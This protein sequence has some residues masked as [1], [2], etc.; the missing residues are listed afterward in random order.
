MN[1]RRLV[2]IASALALNAGAFLQLKWLCPQIMWCHAC[3][4]SVVACPIGAIGYYISFA[5]FPI[6]AVG[7]LLAIAA[8]VGRLLCGWVCPF[9]FLQDLL[10]K[11]PIR[12]FE[13]PAWTS[14]IKYV[15]LIVTVF[16]AAAFLGQKSVLYFCRTCPVATFSA[17]VPKIT[18][19][20][21]EI[22]SLVQFRLGLLAALIVLCVMVSRAFC[23]LICPVAA[24]V[25]PFN[26]IA[27]TAVR[28][29]GETCVTCGVCR[30]VCPMGLEPTK[31]PGGEDSDFTTRSECIN[32]IECVGKCPK[33]S[34]KLGL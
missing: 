19:G 1:S 32:C 4:A 9:G 8:L 18:Q 15:I 12:K 14:K 5:L 11:I 17:I 27:A 10:H 3:P 22:T 30:K 31:L 28:V 13:L 16:G 33:D 29:D 24:L 7:L 21:F 23:R 26:E 6:F 34:L 2:Q 20:T 25:A